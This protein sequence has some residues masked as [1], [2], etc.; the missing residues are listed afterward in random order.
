MKF[1]FSELFPE[2][3]FVYE[4]ISDEE[5][6]QLARINEKPA[7]VPRMLNYKQISNISQWDDFD[8]KT[9]QS[10]SSKS[11]KNTNIEGN[12]VTEEE[13]LGLHI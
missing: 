1:V 6:S 7:D 11:G 8:D 5:L 10:T 2:E 13:R 9:D 3:L 12:L 4:N